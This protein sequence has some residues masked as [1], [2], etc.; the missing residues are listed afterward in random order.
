MEFTES[1]IPARESNERCLCGDVTFWDYTDL[2][3]AAGMPAS[4]SIARCD[5]TEEI[6][7]KK[8]AFNTVT[9]QF[10]VLDTQ[11]KESL[12]G[13]DALHARSTRNLRWLR[14]CNWIINPVA[15]T[16]LLWSIYRLYIAAV[17]VCPQ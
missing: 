1:S 11:F 4:D 14:V 3:T 15:I 5:T 2:W 10:A 16:V 12:A 6:E 7:A 17:A 8:E 13:L 9:E